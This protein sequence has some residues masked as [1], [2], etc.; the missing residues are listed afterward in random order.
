M[1]SSVP[2]TEHKMVVII[3]TFNKIKLR[4]EETKLDSGERRRQSWTL[5]RE[6][7]KAGLWREKETK[8]DSGERRR[9][10]WREK[11]TKLERIANEGV[12]S[13]LDLDSR[14]KLSVCLIN[15]KSHK[16]YQV[17]ES[18]EQ[19]EIHASRNSC[20]KQV[21]P[22]VTSSSN[23][24]ATNGVSFSANCLNFPGPCS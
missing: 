7:D 16:K 10:G 11:E 14:Y 20:F 8:L 4:E 21:T 22:A 1:C 9:Q 12:C 3:H 5:E 6:G 19:E 24:S 23:L 13:T 2:H 15:N 17:K 18:Q